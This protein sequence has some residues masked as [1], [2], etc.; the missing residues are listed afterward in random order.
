[1]FGDLKYYSDPSSTEEDD[2]IGDNFLLFCIFIIGVFILGFII[3]QA[4][5]KHTGHYTSDYD[6]QFQELEIDRPRRYADEIENHEEGLYQSNKEQ[7]KERKINELR[8]HADEMENH[9]DEL[10]NL[11]VSSNSN[12]FSFVGY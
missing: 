9:K 5:T 12:A 8:Q 3:R 1:M 11:N 7:Q 4:L 6:E 10:K 2:I